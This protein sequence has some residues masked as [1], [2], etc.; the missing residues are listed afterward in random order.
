MINKALCWWK[1]I[2]DRVLLAWLG[3]LW[4]ALAPPVFAETETF[5]LH[6]APRPAAQA[7][8]YPLR[9][10]VPDARDRRF[11]PFHMGSD[12]VL[13]EKP[14]TAMA[15]LVFAEL[16][17]SGL[18]AEVRRIKEVLPDEPDA[19]SLTAF[20][21]RHGVDLLLVTD[22]RDLTMRREKDDLLQLN[23]V[24]RITPE[25]K[26]VIEAAWV[27]RLVFPDQGIVVW[28]D[29]VGGRAVALAKEETLPVE[30]LGVM[31]RKAIADG[32]AD[33]RLLMARFG[34]RMAQ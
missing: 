7:L 13:R 11:M 8:K 23:D 33:M 19:A 5:S 2:S 16:R 9:L 3:A 4:L 1:M 20:K 14:G 15:D 6:Y 29:L 10:G 27:V 18:F 26:V 25:F 22:L 30:D 28:G 17:A 31:T 12:Q 34:K 24:T 32:M 21:T